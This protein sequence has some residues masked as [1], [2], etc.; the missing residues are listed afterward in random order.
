M[1]RA[2]QNEAD[3]L[4]VR[5]GTATQRREGDDDAALCSG[6]GEREKVRRDAGAARTAGDWQRAELQQTGYVRSLLTHV[7]ATVFAP[8]S[9]P[10]PERP[11]QNN[12][13]LRVWRPM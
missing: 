9:P 5:G 1:V 3:R 2:D 10:P 4:V 12:G 8:H 13:I 7:T 11:F 6:G